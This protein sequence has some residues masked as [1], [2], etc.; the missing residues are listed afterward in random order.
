MANVTFSVGSNVSGRIVNI[1]SVSS[2][3]TTPVNSSVPTV[4]PAQAGTE[5]VPIDAR[6]LVAM[7]A[8]FAGFGALQLRRRSR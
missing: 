6:W 4:V 7:L 8:L 5:R 3:Q 1:A 2:D